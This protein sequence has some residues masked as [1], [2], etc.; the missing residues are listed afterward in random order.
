MSTKTGINEKRKKYKHIHINVHFNNNNKKRE[1]NSPMKN[2]SPT[3]PKEEALMPGMLLLHQPAMLD[4]R[5]RGSQ[6][7]S[8]LIIK[9]KK[10]GQNKVDFFLKWRRDMEAAERL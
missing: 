6:E 3:E 10:T 5:H 7:R 1:R 2:G 9:I 4:R 8:E